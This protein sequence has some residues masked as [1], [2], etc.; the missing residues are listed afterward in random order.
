MKFINRLSLTCIALSIANSVAFA[1][2]KPSHKLL[3]HG[4]YLVAIGGCNDCHTAGY[5]QSGGTLP[6][7]SWLTGN[8]VGFNGPW[9][10]TYAENLRLVFNNMSLDEW[11]E[12]ATQPKRPPMPWF[13]LR[14]MSEKDLIA[15]YQYVRHLGPAGE[16][17]PEYVPPNAEINTPYIEF[18]PKNLP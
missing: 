3:E 8:A 14:D 5:S 15:I 10:T 13:S 18:F 11:L 12:S 4:K 16:P 6:E 7:E 9:G 17:A 1:D 2:E